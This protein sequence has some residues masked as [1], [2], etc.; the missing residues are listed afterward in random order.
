MF[1]KHR[2]ALDDAVRAFDSYFSGLEAEAKTDK[3]RANVK[4]VLAARF[5][6]HW[7]SALLLC[8]AGLIVDV[9]ICERSAIETLAFH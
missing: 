2:R 5:F 8:E 1:T 3:L 7:Y 9:L 6:N 4:K